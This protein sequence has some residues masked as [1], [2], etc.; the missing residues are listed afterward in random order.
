MRI[1]TPLLITGGGPAALVA[2]RVASGSGL[3]SLVVWAETR[4]RDDAPV[5]LGPAVRAILT[6][7]GVL[8]VLR[9]YLAATDPP[10]IAPSL[11]EGVLKHHCVVDMNITV[12]EGMEWTA[13]AGRPGAGGV[14]ELGATRIEV[15][16]DAQIDT[17]THPAE[18]EGAIVAGADAAQAVLANRPGSA[19]VVSMSPGT[20]GRTPSDSR[21]AARR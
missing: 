19:A 21:A 11:F 4:D 15:V 10:A 13:A 16:A 1:D 3:Q 5:V 17:A 14:L 9:P 18:L 2:A 20:E 6:P 12:Y 7:H 8:D